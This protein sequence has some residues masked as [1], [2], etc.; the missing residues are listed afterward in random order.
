VRVALDEHGR[1]L[2]RVGVIDTHGDV[3][4]FVGSAYNAF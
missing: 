3:Q 4:G 2:A 1:W